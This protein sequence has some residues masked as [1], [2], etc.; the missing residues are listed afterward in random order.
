MSESNL[1]L[2]TTPI[3]ST[4]RKIQVVQ[5]DGNYPENPD[6]SAIVQTIEP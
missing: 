6:S 5:N 2:Y 4:T 1:I 3:D